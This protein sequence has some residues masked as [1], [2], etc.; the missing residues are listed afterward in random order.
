MRNAKDEFITHVNR[1][2][3]LCCE[4]HV[5]SRDVELT[6]GWVESELEMLLKNIDIEYD[7]GYGGQE[8]YG[9]IWYKDGTWSTRG[10]YDGSEWW[11]HH[12]VPTIPDHLNRIDKVRDEKL[13]KLIDE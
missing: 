3:I 11:E 2:E 9:T 6:T 7:A 4:I 12:S 8:L 5:H 10:E 1:R 13:N